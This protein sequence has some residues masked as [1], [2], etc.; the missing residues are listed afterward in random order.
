MALISPVVAAHVVSYACSSCSVLDS[1]GTH[2]PGRVVGSDAA[3]RHEPGPWLCGRC[4]RREWAAHLE[5]RRE[6]M[7]LVRLSWRL[8][9]AATR[10]ELARERRAGV[11]MMPPFCR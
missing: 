3:Y 2:G 9:Y 7:A 1:S 6:R 8:G 11:Q 5:T 10:A 4:S